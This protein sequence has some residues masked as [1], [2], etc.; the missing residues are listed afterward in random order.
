[1]SEKEYIAKNFIE[2]II[3]HDNETHKYDNRVHTRF[4]PEPNGYLHIGH[5]KSICLNFSLAK[6]Y[7]GKTNLR[8]DDTN[9]TTEDVEYVDSIRNDIRWLGF[10]WE[11]REFYSSDYFDQMYEMARQLIIKGKAY[12]DDSSAAEMADMKGTPTIP[13]KNSPYY[14]RSVE[15]NISLFEK[16]KNGELEEGSCALRARIDM[17]SP[18]MIMRDPVIYRIKKATHH[19]TGDTWNIYPMYDFA[20]CISDSIEKITHSICT[21]EFEVHR[22]LYDWLLIELGLYRPQQ[23]EFA[24]LNLTYTMMSKRKLL[25]LVESKTVAGWDDPRMPTISGMRRRGYPAAAIREFA[26]GVGIAKRDN[27]I[28][29]ELLEYHVREELNKIAERVMVVFD[30]IE[31]EITNYADGKEETLHIEI[32]P[33]DEQAGKREVPFTKHLLIE[34]D[35]FMEVPPPKYFRLSPGGYVRLKGAYIIKCEGLEKN[36]DGSIRKILASY[37]ENSRS[38]EDQSGIKVSGTIHWVSAPHAL[39]AEARNYNRLFT[40]LNP[41]ESNP[42][43]GNG[44]TNDADDFLRLVNPES[45]KTIQVYAEPYLKNAPVGKAYQFIRKGYYVPDTTSSDGQLVFNQTVA[46]KDAWKKKN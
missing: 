39:R 28:E 27:M 1:M 6:K 26:H 16:M 22:P 33:E 2:E 15:E 44:E 45:V 46:L 43:D 35:D 41:S 10:D 8:F 17:A 7:Q 31:I 11:D 36:S 21:L 24:R 3:D 37:V 34:S 38:G 29:V 30:P 12:V 20:H 25:K 18:N 13:G 4:P 19:R 40:Q 5:A 42:L 14:S 23:I 9:P 32:N